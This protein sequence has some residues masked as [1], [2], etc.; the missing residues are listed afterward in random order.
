[1]DSS[2]NELFSYHLPVGQST[3]AVRSALGG[4]PGQIVLGRMKTFARS[5]HKKIAQISLAQNFFVPFNRVVRR[6]FFLG[7]FVGCYMRRPEPVWDPLWG[8]ISRS[9]GA[10]RMRFSRC[11]KKRWEQ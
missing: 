4:L 5:E 7:S 2:S 11:L 8:L 10:G 3:Q 9:K 1:M 6:R